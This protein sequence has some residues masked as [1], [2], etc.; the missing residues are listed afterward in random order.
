MTR[1]PD[2][3]DPWSDYLWA[4]P[5]SQNNL[6][7]TDSNFLHNDNKLFHN[8][9]RAGEQKYP[10]TVFC[11]CFF[12][13]VFF[14]FYTIALNVSVVLVHIVLS[15]WFQGKLA[16]FFI[17]KPVCEQLKSTLSK[18][19]FLRTIY[20]PFPCY[21]FRWIKQCANQ[22]KVCWKTNSL[23]ILSLPN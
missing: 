3:S 2:R 5:R 9:L 21:K 23:N 4:P 17:I 16:S 13:R 20:L 19:F 11:Q 22:V 10:L 18:C 14:C 8:V 1:W 7:L 12:S 6:D 15:H